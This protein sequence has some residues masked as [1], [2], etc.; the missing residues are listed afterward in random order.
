MAHD[1][2]TNPL[3]PGKLELIE[4]VAANMD[5]PWRFVDLGGLW[6]VHGA[7]ALHALAQ[8]GCIGG[9][10]IDTHPTQTFRDTLAS[11]PTLSFVQGNFG[12]AA[13]ADEL[14]P[15]DVVLL[16]DT[17]LHQVSPDWDEVLSMYAERAS[18]ILVF[19]QQYCGTKTVRLLDL[20]EDEYFQNVPH[21]RAHPTYSQLFA[22]LDEIHPIHNRPWRDVHHIWQWGITDADLVAHMHSLGFEQVFYRNWGQ[23][24]DLKNF[25]NHA[26]I[27]VRTANAGRRTLGVTRVPDGMSASLIRIDEDLSTKAQGKRLTQLRALRRQLAPDGI[28]ELPATDAFSGNALLQ[29]ARY[30]GLFP[31]EGC[32]AGQIRLQRPVRNDASLNWPLVTLAIPAFKAEHFAECFASALAQSYPSIQLLVCDDSASDTLKQIA[33]LH[34]PPPGR[35]IDWVSNAEN[36]GGRAN[37]AQCLEQARGVYIKFLCDDDILEPDCVARMVEAF[38][39]EPD[40]T[41]VFARRQR[42]DTLGDPLPDNEH[43]DALSTHDC[44]FPGECLAGAVMALGANFIGE[45]TSVMFR[46]E[47]LV[48]IQPHYASIG[49]HDDIR[50][51]GDIAAWHNLL[52]Q[53]EAVYLHDVLSRFRI[54]PGQNQA[55]PEIR[56]LANTA[57]K[58]LLDASKRLGFTTDPPTDLHWRPLGTRAWLDG[59]SEPVNLRLSELRAREGLPD[60]PGLAR[61]GIRSAIAILEAST[62]EED[63][64][65]T[66]EAANGTAPVPQDHIARHE[67]AVLLMKEGHEDEGASMLI[68][69]ATENTPHWEV[70]CDL[71]E[72][73]LARGDHE[74]AL[75][76]MQTATAMGPDQGRAVLGLA[77]LRAVEGEHEAAVTSIG[78]WLRRYPSDASALMALRQV[79]GN[80]PELSPV[81]WSRLM[82]DL[83]HEAIRLRA[84][85][86]DDGKRI[87]TL[88][89]MLRSALHPSPSA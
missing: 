56:A 46:R 21:D 87:R 61:L 52:S 70:Y 84:R 62:E 86:S 10:E 16:F 71:A 34:T 85:V 6:A 28:L 13:I 78:R 35:T 14:P 57:W 27:F 25:E 32:A 80:A 49:G 7:Y 20:G 18:R 15:F 83:R 68:A 11:A 33:A 76:L 23:V 43:T 65:C 22:R 77:L 44:V 38:R 55:H 66:D 54:H 47:D 24:L 8:P 58:K 37:F 1:E 67:Q 51:V 60:V 82:S 19:N 31:A 53:G 50:V 89:E 29:D 9:T 36:L 17:L 63:D 41:L 12:D 5:G 48:W 40:A 39:R 45:P 72:F 64:Q 26:F 81:V 79:L 74:A 75:D 69:L 73:A 30:A 4:K 3:H 42:I 2:T 59:P 88:L